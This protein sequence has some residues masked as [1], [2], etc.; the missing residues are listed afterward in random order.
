MHTSS[1][2]NAAK[3]P[4]GAIK[5][6]YWIGDCPAG[7]HGLNKAS[8]SSI[9]LPLS[10]RMDVDVAVGRDR[11]CSARI[12][13]DECLMCHS[14]PCLTIAAVSGLHVARQLIHALSVCLFA[15]A[16]VCLLGLSL[17]HRSQTARRRLLSTM[18]PHSDSSSL[19]L[20]LTE[21]FYTRR[22]R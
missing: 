15:R 5:M 20:L 8:M 16:C 14:S 2:E 13:L 22:R 19:T 17:Q 11:G 10:N 7:A 21:R 12:V 6:A 18:S 1:G 4:A 9:F 3:V